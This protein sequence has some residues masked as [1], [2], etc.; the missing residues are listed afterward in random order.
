M[1]AR[2]AGG[3]GLPSVPLARVQPPMNGKFPSRFVCSAG[4]LLLLTALAKMISAFGGA[5]V[6]SVRDP[7]LKLP[8]REV[9]MLVGSLELVVASICFFGRRLDFQIKTVA[10]LATLFVM[11]RIG[12]FM[13]D[14]HMPCTCLGSMTDMLHIPFKSSALAI[15]IILAYLLV[16]S[17]ALLLRLWRQSSAGTGSVAPA[18][19][20]R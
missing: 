12:L 14:Y 17:Y 18:Q 20:P 13:V 8:F 15:E 3:S 1:L 5:Q 2:A 7:I 10:W 11:Y 19:S 9:F 4:A 6:L 16:G